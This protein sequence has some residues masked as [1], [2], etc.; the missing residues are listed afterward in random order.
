V[1]SDALRRVMLAAEG[2]GELACTGVSTGRAAHPVCGDEVAVDVVLRDG[3]VEDLAWRARGCPA[4]LAVAAA[5]P[6]AL[7]GALVGEAAPRLRRRLDQLGG[8]AAHERHAERLFLDA[9]RAAA[10]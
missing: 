8:L 4:C 5:A 3:V 7:R 9:L 6:A 2:S 10:P 1:V